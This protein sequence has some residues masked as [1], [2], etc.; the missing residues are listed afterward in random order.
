MGH[1]YSI[2]VPGESIDEDKLEH[3]EVIDWC[4]NNLSNSSTNAVFLSLEDVYMITYN[5]QVLDI[6]N[7]ENGGMLQSGE[8]DWIISQDVKNKVLNRLLVLKQTM[9]GREKEIVEGIIMLLELAIRTRKNIYF[10]F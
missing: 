10:I 3:S 9:G 7:K 2:Y 6:I 4:V 8:D 5:C 1:L